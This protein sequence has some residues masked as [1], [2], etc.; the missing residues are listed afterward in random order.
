MKLAYQKQNFKS[1]EMIESRIENYWNKRSADFSRVR[2]IELSGANGEAWL[3][4]I[5][6]HLPNQKPLKIL[7]VGTGAGFFAILLANCGHKVTGIDMSPKMIHESKKN[8]FE[9]G[10][11]AEFKLMNAQ[12]LIFDDETFDVVISRN[13]TWTLPDVMQAYQEWHRVLKVG[14]VLINFDSD[15]GD[16]NFLN[17]ETCSKAQVV[18]EMLIECNAI[19]DE[20]KISSHRRPSWDI[21]FLQKLNFEINFDK[22]ISP[23]V[24]QDKIDYDSVPLFGIYAKKLR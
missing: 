19:K 24:H 1:S 17:E 9:F 20:L 4:L 5:Q 16:K 7:D 13:L 12:E 8:M 14:G 3:S 6:K 2:R 22:D 18:D 11:R 23:I 21:E 15:Y 10:C